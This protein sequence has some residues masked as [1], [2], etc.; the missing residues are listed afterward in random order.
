VR[1]LCGIAL[2]FLVCSVAT[3][4]RADGPGSEAPAPSGDCARSLAETVQR[5]YDSVRDLQARFTQTTRRVSLGTGDSDAPALRSSGEA[6]FAKPGRM[7]WSYEEPEPSLVVSD[8]ETLWLYDP[9]LGEAQRLAVGQA[10]LS[11]AAIQFLLGEGDLLRDFEVS[12]RECASARPELVL[13]PRQ[14]ATYERL[15]LRVDAATGE[16]VETSVV[17]LF[18]NVTRVSFERIRTNQDPAATTFRFEPPPGTRVL[19]LPGP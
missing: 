8:G 1:E 9:G 3:L 11:G 14:D 2:V 5:H 18:G 16:V 10:F 13:V 7:R 12:A 4:A 19:E 6:V 17:D 15:E